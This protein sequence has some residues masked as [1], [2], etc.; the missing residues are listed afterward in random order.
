MDLTFSPV[1]RARKLSTVFG[2]TSA[3]SCI[4]ILPTGIPAMATSKKTLGLLIPILTVVHTLWKRP[5]GM[6]NRSIS[7]ASIQKWLKHSMAENI[8]ETQSLEVT[9]LSCD[10]HWNGNISENWIHALMDGS[11]TGRVLSFEWQ[12]WFPQNSV[13]T[14][15][16]RRLWNT[17]VI[18]GGSILE[19]SVRQLSCASWH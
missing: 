14:E 1:Q 3:K 7:L 10:S 16:P 15:Q 18:H 11:T 6:W 12:Y 17:Q 8:E 5:A 13:N 2:Q 9:K 4:T 19:Q